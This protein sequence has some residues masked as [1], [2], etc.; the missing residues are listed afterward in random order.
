MMRGIVLGLEYIHNQNIVHRDLKPENILVQDFENLSGLKIADF[1]TAK[2]IKDGM[3]MTN[4]VSTRWYRAPECLLSSQSYGKPADIFA[5]GCIL[6]EFV[7]LKPIFAGSS[8][9]D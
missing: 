3:A 8:S 1:G 5:L 7:N 4:Y 2:E 6:A 9:S